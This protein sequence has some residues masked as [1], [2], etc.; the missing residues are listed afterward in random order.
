MLICLKDHLDNFFVFIFEKGKWWVHFIIDVH[1]ISSAKIA[2]WNSIAPLISIKPNCT[3]FDSW[4]FAKLTWVSTLLSSLDE[5]WH[6]YVLRHPN[7][8]TLLCLIP[9]T[10]RQGTIK[11][12]TILFASLRSKI[13]PKTGKIKWSIT[14]QRTIDWWD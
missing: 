2:W 7:V 12:I 4:I 1:V 11:A 13:I 5:L 9:P 10:I 6:T 8:C 14:I 3:W